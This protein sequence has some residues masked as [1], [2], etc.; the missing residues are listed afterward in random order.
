MSV[1]PPKERT[2]TEE[3]EVAG[4]ELVDRVQELVREGN[5]RRLIIRSEDGNKL[6]EIPLTAGAV[7]GGAAVI[8][9]PWLTVLG[10][11]AA[12][13]ARVRIEVVHNGDGQR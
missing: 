2:W 5:V 12:L 6:L 8:L 10:V 11:I 1:K 3:I 7:A 13:V 4:N 9:A